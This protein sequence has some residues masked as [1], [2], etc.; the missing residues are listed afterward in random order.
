MIYESKFVLLQGVEEYFK[1]FQGNPC[2]ML[3]A[4][5]LSFYVFVSTHS[6][7]V[8]MHV[9]RVCVCVCVCLL[10]CAVCAYACDSVLF[11]FAH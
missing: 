7:S 3:D 9:L 8:H 6:M 10:A 2:I 11:V 1:T 5:K 4:H